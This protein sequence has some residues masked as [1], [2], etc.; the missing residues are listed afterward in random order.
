MI[1][2]SPE[3]HPEYF[4][5]YATGFLPGEIAA[6]R[7]TESKG[8]VLVEVDVAD[9][10]WEPDFEVPWADLYDTPWCPVLRGLDYP[11][12]YVGT[13]ETVTLPAG[14]YRD[15]TVDAGGSLFF[16]GGNGTIVIHGHLSVAGTLTLPVSPMAWS[17][18]WSTASG[19][20]PLKTQGKT[21]RFGRKFV[22]ANE[23]K[24]NPRTGKPTGHVDKKF[25]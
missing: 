2:L 19:N 21:E 11:S 15:V 18:S 3:D 8:L 17:G 9:S 5:E 14:N 22:L 10:E 23:A 25:R 13:G 1:A 16:E 24:W 4:A 7:V 20:T 6:A 12:I